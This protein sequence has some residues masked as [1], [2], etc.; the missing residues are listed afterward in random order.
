MFGIKLFTKSDFVDLA[1][2]AG[3][4][5]QSLYDLAVNNIRKNIENKQEV[6]ATNRQV[7]AKA[8]AEITTATAQL[9]KANSV[10]KTANKLG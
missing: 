5:Y 4:S 9:K 6:I 3:M 7:I 8:E 10:L 2:A 1:E